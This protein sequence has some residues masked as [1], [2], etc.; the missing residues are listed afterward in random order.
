VIARSPA[1][2]ARAGVRVLIVDDDTDIADLLSQALQLEGFETEVAHDAQAALNS[3]RI[4]SPHAAV[5][6]VGLPQ[7]DG[8]ELAKSLRAEHGR[9]PTLIAATGYG[10]QQDRLRAA[11]AG[12]D[13][14]FVKPVSVHDLLQA[15]D[16]ACLRFSADVASPAR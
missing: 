2:I 6:D 11:D 4:F 14:H 12:F 13:C 3:F 16:R 10:Q 7:I 1:R 8:Y 15:L 9:K 5:L